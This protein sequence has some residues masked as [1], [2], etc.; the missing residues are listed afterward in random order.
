MLHE[1][2]MLVEGA[3]AVGPAAILEYPERFE[4]KKTGV[5]ISGGNLDLNI[6]KKVLE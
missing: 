5:V 1:N 3:G 6:L 2:H 4:N